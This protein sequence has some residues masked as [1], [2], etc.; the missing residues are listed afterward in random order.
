MSRERSDLHFVGRRDEILPAALNFVRSSTFAITLVT[1]AM[2]AH[3]AAFAQGPG[4]VG[5]SSVRSQYFENE[6]LLF[7]VPEPFDN[8][9]AALATGD[10]NG[11]G[12]DDLA[13]GIPYD[14]GLAGF[15]LNNVGLVVVRY[16][17][18]GFGLETG[19]AD[20]VLRQTANPEAGDNF[21]FALAAGDF[22]GDGYD[23]LAVGEP[24]SHFFNYGEVHIFYGGPG[25][26]QLLAG[27]SFWYPGGAFEE[28]RFGSVL[29]AGN[30]NGDSF[31]DLA[32]GLPHGSVWDATVQ[33][34]LVDVGTVVVIEGDN[35][36]MRPTANPVN[37]FMINQYESGIPDS[38]D[39]GDL[40]GFSLAVGNFNGDTQSIGNEVYDFDD[41]AIGVPGED[42]VG[43]ILVLYGSQWNL[44][45][46]SSVFL[47]EID[48]GSLPETDD[49]FG[50]SLAAADFDGNGADD[51][52]IGAPYED[53][54]GRTDTG[55][56][57]VLY[58][59]M[60]GGFNFG[61]NEW[62]SQA[63]I[64]GAGFARDFDHFGQALTSL[65]FDPHWDAVGE[66]F[67]IAS[68]VVGTP[69]MSTFSGGV[70]VVRGTT[71]GLGPVFKVGLFSSD[72]GAAPNT[73]ESGSFGGVLATGDFDGN[74]YEDLVIGHPQRV[75]GGIPGAGSELVLYSSTFGDGFDNFGDTF[76][77][78]ATIP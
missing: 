51:L 40:F 28:S 33:G 36:G 32:M 77:W 10:F 27:H 41:L 25:G 12:A 24:G 60:F 19:L 26:I 63:S 35:G 65:R 48:W 21:G 23:D 47:G 29:V 15:E 70:T 22:N 74:G 8:F 4:W 42:G 62:W 64:Y 58:G 17:I 31:D 3:P 61:L 72:F 6:N 59:Q 7:Y 5:L 53:L 52:A 45:F 68:L 75:V 13:T 2:V 43:A 11:D 18:P 73:P 20:T 78:S 54:G 39:A 66:P 46:G 16:G 9:G 34:I 49:Y 69:G 56:V 67:G 44:L 37:W 1:L 50:W 14:N 55:L 38:P 30:F 57:T 71:A 76:D